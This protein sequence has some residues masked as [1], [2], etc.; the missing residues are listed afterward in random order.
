M[1]PQGQ[2]DMLELALSDDREQS[3]APVDVNAPVSFPGALRLLHVAA[4]HNQPHVVEYLLS[5]GSRLDINCRDDQFG[6]SALGLAVLCK[7]MASCLMLLR[8]GADATQCSNAGKSPLFFAMQSFPDAVKDIVTIGGVNIN[9]PT[10]TEPVDSLPLTLAVLFK[11]QHLITTLIE[12]G[13]DVNKIETASS[14]TALYHAIAQ[15]DYFATKC[16]LQN[17]ALPNQRCLR[18]QT[19]MFAAVEKG[20]TALIRLLVEVSTSTT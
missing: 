16:L 2:V 6:H 10:T 15:E 12:L 20:N 3:V 18:G 19:P 5:L 9:A 7:N 4:H 14:K 11:R 8:A 13:A 17:G 1:P